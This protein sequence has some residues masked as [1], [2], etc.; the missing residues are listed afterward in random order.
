VREIHHYNRNFDRK[1][2]VK[3]M[4]VKI[5]LFTWLLKIVTEKSRPVK[6]LIYR[7]F[8]RL[9]VCQIYSDGIQ[10][11]CMIL[12]EKFLSKSL[13]LAGFLNV[14]GNS[15]EIFWRSPPQFWQIQFFPS[16]LWWGFV[17]I[18]VT[19]FDKISNDLPIVQLFILTQKIIC[20]F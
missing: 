1:Q 14:G 2:F 4:L 17:K 16:K 3:K 6:I 7:I 11:C 8:D 9:I 20:M 15:N 12:T 5:E 13:W 19:I 10:Y 18:S